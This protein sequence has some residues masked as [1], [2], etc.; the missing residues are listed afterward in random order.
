MVAKAAGISFHQALHD[1]PFAIGLQIIHAECSSE[2]GQRI[3]SN[4][5]KGANKDA[6]KQFQKIQ[7][8]WQQQKS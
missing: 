5:I 7:K 2:G 1:L 3:F 4:K 8:T 6:L